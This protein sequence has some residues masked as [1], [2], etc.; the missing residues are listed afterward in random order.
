[1]LSLF[2]TSHRA[3]V[4]FW[5]W[6]SNLF[7][8]EYSRLYMTISEKAQNP[9]VDETI[10]SINCSRES[11]RTPYGETICF[12][13]PFMLAERWLFLTRDP[14]RFRTFH[15]R[16]FIVTGR[17]LSYSCGISH[18]YYITLQK[19]EKIYDIKRLSMQFSLYMKANIYDLNDFIRYF[20]CNFHILDEN[21][22]C[23]LNAWRKCHM[24]NIQCANINGDMN[25]TDA[26]ERV[27]RELIRMQ[28]HRLKSHFLSL[29]RAI[30][31]QTRKR[32]IRAWI[33]LSRIV[34]RYLKYFSFYF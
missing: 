2:N 12:W 7:R 14:Q 18:C 13:S 29:R 25:V 22:C 16:P 17:K 3:Y 32:V 15:F 4:F 30:S 5:E 21:S 1:M 26:S 24:S 6:M 19:W 9:H 27:R 28:R 20:Q 33:S 34:L 11:S 10:S 8:R 23:Q 31:A